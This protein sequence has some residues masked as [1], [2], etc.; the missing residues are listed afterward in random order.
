MSGM[1]VTL[2]SKEDLFDAI[3]ILTHELDLARRERDAALRR[4]EGL[5]AT[6]AMLEAP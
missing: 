1:I 4:E 2:P 6:L 3:E 5:M